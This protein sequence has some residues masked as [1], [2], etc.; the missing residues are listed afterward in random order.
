MSRWFSTTLRPEIVYESLEHA[1]IDGIC[2]IPVDATIIPDSLL[3]V[4]TVQISVEEDVSDDTL[5]ELV[6]IGYSSC[7]INEISSSLEMELRVVPLI[8]RLIGDVHKTLKEFLLAV[9]E[10]RQEFVERQTHLHRPVCP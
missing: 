3:G 5:N 7:L 9:R 8:I 4:T 6:L 10:R 2:S 1:D